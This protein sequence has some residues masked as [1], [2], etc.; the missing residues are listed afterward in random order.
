MRGPVLEAIMAIRPE[1]DMRSIQKAGDK[2]GIEASLAARNMVNQRLRIEELAA[3]KRAG[4]ITDSEQAELS[5]L[6]TIRR[7]TMD[8]MSIKASAHNAFRKAAAEERTIQMNRIR[9]EKRLA[10]ERAQSF[11]EMKRGIT[12]TGKMFTMMGSLPAGMM[13]KKTLN[14]VV[15]FQKE[16]QNTLVHFGETYSKDMFK[17]AKGQVDELGLG[18]KTALQYAT[19]VAAMIRAQFPEHEQNY[20]STRKFM[21]EKSQEL[22]KMAVDMGSL[23]G[24]TNEEMMGKVGSG[25]AGMSRPL[26]EF[27]IDIS[28]MARKEWAITNAKKLGLEV[29]AKALAQAEKGAVRRRELQI[30]DMRLAKQGYAESSIERQ[31]IAADMKA[32]DVAVERLKVKWDVNDSTL[33]QKTLM[34]KMEEDAKI[35]KDAF[36]NNQ[37]LYT[38]N[39]EKLQAAW[40]NF[41]IGLG[42]H[43]LPVAMKVVRKLIEMAKWFGTLS[44]GT[45]KFIVIALALVAVLGPTILMLGMLINSI[46]AIIAGWKALTAVINMS[47]IAFLTHPVFLMAIAITALIYLIYQY[48][49]QIWTFIKWVAEKVKW[50]AEHGLLGPLIPA[51]LW[52][53]RNWGN[54]KEW[55]KDAV[56]Y[57]I[58]KVEWMANK[59]M[60]I[61]MWPMRVVGHLT[62]NETMKNWGK[63]EIP[64]LAT[65]GTVH[66]G[67]RIALLGDGGE[68]EDVVPHSKRGGYLQALGGNSQGD[69]IAEI[70]ALRAD[71]N[72][73]AESPRSPITVNTQ[74]R[75]PRQ[76]AVHLDDLSRANRAKRYQPGQVVTR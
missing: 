67:G 49:D 54:V 50:M 65:G 33:R 8:E 72:V 20:E 44:S 61:M 4:L 43:V 73:L 9:D 38:E 16:Q 2:A 60:T 62:D 39:I 59:I 28:V 69:L 31:K 37:H 24:K 57:I 5:R 63:V 27:G 1:L 15:A 75:D 34:G 41:V 46:T 71:I 51:F 68:P 26:R 18:E 42:E 36:K 32:L 21:A 11:K 55:A 66:P 29:D 30:K 17:W 7:T 6:R 22:V 58:D 19:S 25:L 48:R 52:L 45:K 14:T 70:R 74:L 23:F 13:L 10:A 12:E 76:V 53:K 47:K 64:R 3:R 40:E 35:A 56:N